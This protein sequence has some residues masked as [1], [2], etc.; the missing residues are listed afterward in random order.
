MF[1]NMQAADVFQAN[2]FSRPNSIQTR[3]CDVQFPHDET[4]V[5]TNGEERGFHTIKYQIAQM[6]AEILD[7][8]LDLKSP[9]MLAVMSLHTRI[10]EFEENLPYRLRCRTSLLALPSVYSSAEE[11]VRASPDTDRWDLQLTFRQF[12]LSLLISEAL[13]NLHR[14]Y[15][16]K[17]LKS[18]S[19]PVKSPWGASFLVVI[20]RSNVSTD[21]QVA[22]ADPRF[23]SNWPVA[24]MRSTHTCRHATGSCGTTPSTR[25]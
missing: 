24:S 18:G 10:T 19:D 6:S 15:F 1:W 20:E 11:A 21:V 5:E 25:P 9:T 12:F 17:A 14:P 4:L 13:I 8:T 7:Q 3:Y 23:S 16:V 2:C 22:A